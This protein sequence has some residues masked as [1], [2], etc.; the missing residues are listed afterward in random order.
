MADASTRST[1]PPPSTTPPAAS[2]LRELPGPF[3]APVVGNTLTFLRD[4]V[5]LLQRCAREYGNVFKINVLGSDVVCMCGP[6]AFSMFLDERYFHREDG[7]PSHLQQIFGRNAVPFLDGKEFLARKTLLMAAFDE[8][9][10]DAYAP[11]IDRVIRRYAR[12][13]SDLRAFT[14][15]PE[16]TAMCMTIA[17]ALFLGTNPD[18]D[19]P[20]FDEAFATAR[21]GILAVPVKAPF[22]KF[23]RSLR[24]RDFILERIGEA[25][26]AHEGTH[27]DDAM[28]RL[29]AARTKDGA[30]LSRTEAQTEIFHFFFAYLPVIGGLT[31]LAMLLAQH[32]DVMRRV[33]EEIQAKLPDGPLTVSRL[34]ALEYLDAVCKES[35][36]VQPVLGF[37]FFANVVKEC[38]YKDIRIPSGIK[39][40]G[41]IAPTLLD[42]KNFPDP[43][44]FDPDRW[45]GAR[46]T[47]RQRSG[48]VAQG[49][50]T[51]LTAHRCAGEQLANLMLES[52]AVLLL[53]DYE[54]T[55][56]PQDT[57]LVDGAL[58]A[59]PRSDLDVRFVRRKAD[60]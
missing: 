13:W 17:G 19:D 32:P 33:R 18:V 58:F 12:K 53:R 57:S 24:A 16:I 45:M 9:A 22:T 6:E 52:F 36:R 55:L 25:I 46:P 60:A 2:E 4:P 37:T 35:R 10:L 20:R 27:R 14:W 30:R 44:R 47:E 29:L 5:G 31:M 42:P 41:A 11:V 28:A 43:N 1:P 34:R 38:A 50:G 49:G 59:T 56:P 3:A 21:D 26:D 23:G 48:W 15:V 7:S 8:S 51:Y 39:A 54:W 40:L